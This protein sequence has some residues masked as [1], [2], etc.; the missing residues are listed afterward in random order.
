[1]SLRLKILL[2]LL[3]LLAAALPFRGEIRAAL[4]LSG[5]RKSVAE[6]LAQYEPEVRQRLAPD[7]QRCGL[8]WTPS[9]LVLIGFKKERRLEVWAGEGKSLKLVKSYPILGASGELGPK[10]MEGDNQV[11]E[12]L[13]RVESLNPNSSFHLS[14]RV[15]YPNAFDRNQ[16]A[17]DGRKELGGDIM[18]HGSACSIGCLA[19]GDAAA[20]ALFV[21]AAH[22]KPG[23]VEV[24]LC[25]VDFRLHPEYQAPSTA[26]AW[27]GELYRQLREALAPYR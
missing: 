2:I 18:I 11:P 24:I 10:L 19:M 20:E 25:P 14:L 27:C 3:L 26:P 22:A 5:K 15:S 6:R 9:R 4:G 1:M 21:L 8:S 13:Y 23:S 16:A 12:G 17:L 7:L